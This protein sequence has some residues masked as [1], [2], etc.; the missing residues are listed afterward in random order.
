MR[1]SFLARG[2]ETLVRIAK[3]LPETKKMSMNAG[4]RKKNF[5][6][7]HLSPSVSKAPQENSEPENDKTPVND[8]KQVYLHFLRSVL[9]EVSLLASV[10]VIMIMSIF[11]ES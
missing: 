8:K 10:H 9:F 6:F 1:G 5:V 3:K 2:E 11:S 4:G 7:E